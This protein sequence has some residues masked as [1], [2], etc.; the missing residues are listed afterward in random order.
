MCLPLITLSQP[1]TSHQLLLLGAVDEYTHHSVH[2]TQPCASL[3]QA[4]CWHL[5]KTKTFLRTATTENWPDIKHVH[6]SL[7]QRQIHNQFN[8]RVSSNA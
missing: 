4:Y 3:Q 5:D 6:Y 8:Q 1:L 2:I 7:L